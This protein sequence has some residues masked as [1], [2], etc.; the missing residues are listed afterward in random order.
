MIE[1]NEKS[2]EWIFSGVG[3]TAI[4]IVV[5]IYLHRKNQNIDITLNR[6]AST[7]ANIKE[8]TL[9]AKSLKLDG[10]FI[11]INSIRRISLDKKDLKTGSGKHRH[12]WEWN[13][14]I[15]ISD[16]VIYSIQSNS[17]KIERLKNA[18]E[19]RINGDVGEEDISFRL[20]RGG[21]HEKRLVDALESDFTEYSED[22]MCASDVVEK[23]EFGNWSINGDGTV[24]DHDN[25]LMW[26]QAPWGMNWNGKTFT[27][28]PIVISWVDAKNLFG[29]GE[30]SGKSQY[31]RLNNCE[32]NGVR[33]EKGF[34]RGKCRIDFSGTDD[35][36]LATAHDWKAIQFMSERFDY[37]N[38]EYERR[39]KHVKKLF[40][41]TNIYQQFWTATG[42][43]HPYMCEQEDISSLSGVSKFFARLEIAISKFHRV[44][45]LKKFRD[46]GYT[47]WV[48]DFNNNIDEGGHVEYPVMFVRNLEGEK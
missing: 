47:A 16:D 30:F 45:N 15:H 2:F 17:K 20:S 44:F 3:A 18:L 36:R 41:Y 25:G 33:Y 46:S 22:G 42:K 40:P 6:S 29:K 24:T 8:I 39:K 1:L 26:I 14:K 19:T 31:G 37:P 34:V 28:E 11:S 21:I 35:W 27:G 43:W 4:A 38:M 10:H 9:Y 12:E 7:I 32:L 13:L 48:C 5:A 23:E